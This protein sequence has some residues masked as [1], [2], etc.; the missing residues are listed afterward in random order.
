MNSIRI[1]L[2]K[3]KESMI[4]HVKS[5]QTLGCAYW[6]KSRNKKLEVGDICYLYLIGKGHYQVRYRLE[7]VDTNC[8]RNDSSCWIAPFKADNNCYKL[9]PTAEMYMGNK[10]SLDTLENIG[11]NRHS[12]FKELNEYQEVFLSQYFREL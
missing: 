12:Q 10:L 11:V 8:T 2:L 5:I 1:F 6:K 9:V 3:G 4:N 7:V